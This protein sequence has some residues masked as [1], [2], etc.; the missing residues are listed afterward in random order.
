MWELVEI[1][2][3]HLLQKTSQNQISAFR[4]SIPTKGDLT[5]ILN[6]L[7]RRQR[8]V[9]CLLHSDLSYKQIAQKLDMAHATVRVTVAKLRKQ[10]GPEVVPVLRR[11]TKQQPSI[12]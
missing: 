11:N 1:L 4:A 7:P 5:Q 6:R 10:L 9:L 3:H 2:I 8:D 12:A